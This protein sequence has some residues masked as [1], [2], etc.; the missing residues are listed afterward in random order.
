MPSLNEADFTAFESQCLSQDALELVEYALDLVDKGCTLDLAGVDSG[1]GRRVLQGPLDDWLNFQSRTCSWD[2]LDN[3]AQDVDEICCGADGSLCEG[4][5]FPAECNP[6]CTV[7]FHQFERDCGDALAEIMPEQR[8]AAME[9]FESNCLD[10]ADP[11]FFLDAI[12]SAD[13]P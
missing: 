12:M 4:D 10:S 13:C 5:A 6:G 9:D 7:A 8:V 2:A 11:L 1:N 3:Y